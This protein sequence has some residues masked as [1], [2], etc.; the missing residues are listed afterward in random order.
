MDEQAM[1][2]R[3]RAQ[4]VGERAERARAAAVSLEEVADEVER[5]LAPVLAR[6]GPG[7]W[8]GRA[9]RQ[10]GTAA[11]DAREDLVV[12]ADALREVAREL[13]MSAATLTWRA[14]DLLA[15]RDATVPGEVAR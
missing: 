14:E 13:R 5:R 1:A 6:M 12:A 8:E 15:R 3:R 9:A 4:Q 7:V 11:R 2:L 10:A